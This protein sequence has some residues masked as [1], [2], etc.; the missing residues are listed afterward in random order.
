VN[1]FTDRKGYLAVRAVSPWRFRA[2]PQRGGQPFGAYFTTLELSAVNFF[3]KVR[4][5]VRK[6]R[7]VFRFV[8][9]GDLLPYPGPRGRYVF[10]SPADYFVAPPRQQYAGPA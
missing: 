4:L 9:A 5:P 6:R 7:F 10:Y 2:H 8:D 1:H 3:R